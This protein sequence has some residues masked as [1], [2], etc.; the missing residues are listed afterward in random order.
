VD[1]KLSHALFPGQLLGQNRHRKIAGL[2]AVHDTD[3]MVLRHRFQSR[4]PNLSLA[5]SITQSNGGLL[6]DPDELEQNSYLQ[7]G[8]FHRR[9]LEQHALQ[10][11]SFAFRRG[12]WHFVQAVAPNPVPGWPYGPLRRGNSSATGVP[13]GSNRR[14][15]YIPKRLRYL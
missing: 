14:G 8:K 1:D 4:Q 5:N 3:R 6:A 7:G 10:E 11:C 2:H 9:H 15:V 12:Y 13:V